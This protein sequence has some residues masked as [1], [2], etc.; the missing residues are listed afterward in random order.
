MKG[1]VEIMT[2]EQDCEDKVYYQEQEAQDNF[3]AEME[4]RDRRDLYGN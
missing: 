1:T 4:E 3:D 2:Q